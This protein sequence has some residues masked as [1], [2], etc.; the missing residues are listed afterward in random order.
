VDLE[1]RG[2]KVATIQRRLSAIRSRHLSA[3]QANPAGERVKELMRAISREVG[4]AQQGKA[5]L[6]AGELRAISEALGRSL[7]HVRDRALLVLGF[8]SAL[9]RSELSA[10]DLADLRFVREGLVLRVRRSKNDQKGEG[11]EI[12]IFRG[13]RPSTCPVRTMQAW[14]KLRGQAPGPL[15]LATDAWKLTGRRLCGPSI[16]AIVKRCVEEIGLNPAR[17]GAHSL[18]AGMV[19]AAI[20]AGVPESLVMQRSGHKSLAVMARYVRPARLFTV[21]PLARAL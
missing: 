10:L 8:A 18:R 20:E 12:G 19:T 14:L 21:D 13:R 4:V 6:T 17:Y 7:V 2:R 15:F 11:R 3:G 1:K 9:R 16:C 5:A